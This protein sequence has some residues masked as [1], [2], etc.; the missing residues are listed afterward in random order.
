MF[1]KNIPENLG[2]GQVLRS[3]QPASCFSGIFLFHFCQLGNINLHSFLF[4]FCQHGCVSL[5]ARSKMIVIFSVSVGSHSNGPADGIYTPRRK[6]DTHAFDS[7]YLQYIFDTIT[8][9]FSDVPPTTIE[10]VSFRIRKSRFADSLS[11]PRRRFR[12]G[13][14]MIFSLRKNYN[15]Y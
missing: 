7:R 13:A 5:Q 11:T 3:C 12:A 8:P 14:G 15:I 4:H 9:R 6:I 1:H 10:F 2:R